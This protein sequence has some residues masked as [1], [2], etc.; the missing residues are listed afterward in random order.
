MENNLNE[1][2]SI[3]RTAHVNIVTLLGFCF[4]GSKRALIYEFMSKG[5]L[6][7]YIYDDSKL[8]KIPPLGW[9]IIYHIA[10]DIA[11]GLESL[12]KGCNTQILHLDIKPQNIL[13]DQDFCPK[14]SDFGLAKLCNRKES[15]ISL[16]G[17]RG[18]VGYIARKVFSRNFGIVSHKSDVL[19]IR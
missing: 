1:V 12:H 9:E 2:V 16:V 7:K 10:I 8:N 18:I 11:H 6:E 4:E 13:L 17:A 3:S 5:S 19:A 15:T 14:I